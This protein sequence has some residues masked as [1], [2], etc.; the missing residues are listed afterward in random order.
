MKKLLLI[1]FFFSFLKVDAQPTEKLEYQLRYGF[2]KGGKALLQ[3]S[4][5]VFA[6]KRAIHY[7]LEGKTVGL[8]DKLFRV[9]DI[10]ESIVD[11]ETYLPY[12]AI[13]NIKEQKYHYYNKTYF[14]NDNDSIFSQRTGGMKVPHNMVD[15]LTVFFYMRQNNLLNKLD[16]GEEFTIPVYHGHEYFIMTAKYL[17]TETIKSDIGEKVC[18]VISPQV[19]KGKLLKRSD[20]LKFYITKD[21]NHIPLLLEFD[22]HIGALKCELVSYEKMGIQQMTHN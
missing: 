1:L 6:K 17:G 5:T 2:I 8:T 11:P 4:D 21:K 13:R 16:I 19:S 14:Y 22:M 12:M 15:I 9:H 20:G 7:H 10:Y 3:A 18:H